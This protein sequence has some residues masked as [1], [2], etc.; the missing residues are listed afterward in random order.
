M[1]RADDLVDRG[2]HWWRTQRPDIDSSGKAIVGRILRLQDLA[3]RRFNEALEAFGVR[4][5]EYAVLATLRAK[6][7][8]FRMS[9]SEL[10]ATLLYSSGGLSNLL[11][12][13]EQC[14]YVSRGADPTDGRA[15]PVT[16]TSRG[17]EVADAAMPV[18][19]E[20]EMALISMF[21][22]EER[23][24]FESLLKRMMSVD[25]DGPG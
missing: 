18:H 19:A 25:G 9:P 3:L 10:R 14:G 1:P 13:L 5:Q 4:Y 23:Q 21:D 12:R 8:P 22:Q 17:R 20:A 24:Q 11:K 16:L 7:P 2:F 6:G 15:V